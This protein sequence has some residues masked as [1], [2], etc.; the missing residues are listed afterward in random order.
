MIRYCRLSLAVLMLTLLTV[1]GLPG[2]SLAAEKP[3]LSL[4]EAINLAKENFAIP[5]AYKEFSSNYETNYGQAAWTLS[6]RAV[7][8]PYGE[9]YVRVDAKSGLITNMSNWGQDSLIYTSPIT[10]AQAR[11]AANA[12]LERLLPDRVDQL[13][14]VPDDE[15]ISPLGNSGPSVYTLRWQRVHQGIPFPDNGATFQV[16]SGDGRI[17]DYSLTWTNS[18]LPS[19]SGIISLD[20]ARR[21][22]EASN[23]LELQYFLPQT[24]KPGFTHQRN[25]MLVYRVGAHGSVAIDAFSGQPVNYWFNNESL[26]DRAGGMGG[27]GGMEKNSSLSP[28]EQQ[29]VSSSSQ[30]ISSE[31]AVQAVKK[32]FDVPATLSLVQSSLVSEGNSN[33]HVWNLSWQNEGSPGS[34]YVNARVNARS[35]EVIGFSQDWSRQTGSASLSDEEARQAAEDF[36]KQIQPGRFQETAYEAPQGQQTYRKGDSL[37]YFNYYRVVNGLPFPSNYIN[38]TIDT[39]DKAVITYELNWTDVSFPSSAGVLNKPDISDL[40]L[41]DQPLTLSYVVRQ[42][43]GKPGLTGQEQIG[44]VYKPL[45]GAYST[46]A[47]KLDAISGQPLDWQGAPIVVKR[48]FTFNDVEG[49]PAREDINAAGQA[50]LFGEY[51]NSFHPEEGLTMQCLLTNLLK[52]RDPYLEPKPDD[53]IREARSRGWIKEQLQLAQLV[54]RETMARI[55]VRFI[56]LDRAASAQGI[57]SLPYPEAQ[58]VS[59]DSLGYVALAHGL[60]IVKGGADAYEPGHIMTRAEAATAL[61]KAMKSN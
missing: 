36:L 9:F 12:L 22:F 42:D 8:A 43:P 49:H 11:E 35:G 30:A 26:Y 48:A 56:G 50:G 46:R 44:L 19:P 55:M 5:E 34:S 7:E 38:L 39:Q 10:R 45:Y 27:M 13:Q 58:A 53:L 61:V 17:L 3:N 15:L 18:D 54:D 29:E 25:P 51:G 16:R 23:L 33:L 37:R 6:W 40:F 59:A 4:E 14:W 24:I 47:D 1:I 60:A 20:Q 52:A 21:A 32:W 28:E 57:Y 2:S 41:K 31:Q